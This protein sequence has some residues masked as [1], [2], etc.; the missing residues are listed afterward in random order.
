MHLGQRTVQVMLY[1]CSEAMLLYE[2]ETSARE[3]GVALTES[4]HLMMRDA[5]ASGIAGAAAGMA[6]GAPCC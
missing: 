4:G 6:A 1:Q 3:C 5:G 2:K